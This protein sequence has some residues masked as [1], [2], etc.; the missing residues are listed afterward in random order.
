VYIENQ[1]FGWMRPADYDAIWSSCKSLVTVL[2]ETED[3]QRAI[4]AFQ[5]L[6]QEWHDGNYKVQLENWSMREAIWLP[7]EA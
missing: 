6:P 5:Q 4:D 3:K 2:L 7:E 1:G